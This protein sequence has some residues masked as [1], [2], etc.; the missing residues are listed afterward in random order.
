VIRRGICPQLSRSSG[1][2]V[3]SRIFL[4]VYKSPVEVRLLAN[5][6]ALADLNVFVAWNYDGR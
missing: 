4:R 2:E 3:S 6:S 5:A 1:V